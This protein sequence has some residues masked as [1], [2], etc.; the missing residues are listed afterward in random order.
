MI[1]QI[2]IHL[3]VQFAFIDNIEI[4]GLFASEIYNLHNS[5]YISYILSII[6]IIIFFLSQNFFSILK[7]QNL[8]F[9]GLFKVRRNLDRQGHT[10][11]KEPVI[12]NK[13]INQQINEDEKEESYV[14]C[15]EPDIGFAVYK[16]ETNFLHLTLSSG[17]KRAQC[18]VATR[19]RKAWTPLVSRAVVSLLQSN[20]N[21]RSL[22]RALS[23]ALRNASQLTWFHCPFGSY[24]PCL[25]RW[26]QHGA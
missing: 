11:K 14:G 4:W 21:S 17:N 23:R 24:T 5:E 10:Q 9:K 8:N 22:A 15:H 2:I 26:Q 13:I 25:H 7:I 3:E 1:P 18:L 12:R 19:G 20:P 6:G 16:V